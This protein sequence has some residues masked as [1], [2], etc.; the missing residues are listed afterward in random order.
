MTA[1]SAASAVELGVAIG[2][3]D[4]RLLAGPHLQHDDALAR[5]G[6]HLVRAD[7]EPDL[8]AEAEPVEA[9]G[10]EDTPS[11]PRSAR[12]RRRVSTLPRTGSIWRSG[13]RRRS[14]DARRSERSR[15]VRR[16]A[17]RPRAGR[18][19]PGVARIGPLEARRRTRARGRR[20]RSGPSPSARRRR[21]GRR[22]APPPPRRAKMPR[23]P[24]SANVRR[25]SRSP[26]VD[27]GT[28]A[29]ACP[30]PRSAVAA[31]SACASAS[32]EA[33]VPTRIGVVNW[34]RGRRAR[35]PSAA[36]ARGRPSCGRSARAA[37][38]S[39]SSA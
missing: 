18:A 38:C 6:R 17:P 30:S 32:R 23:P 31:S 28:I 2:R 27:I 35:A 33:R 11:R 14:C 4:E 26:C 10:G 36:L 22:A 37:A 15:P 5:L 39:R 7:P 21:P 34:F 12:L 8:V 3:R 1:R 16:P 20:R 9:G 29:T 24:I 19:D 13:R 25:R